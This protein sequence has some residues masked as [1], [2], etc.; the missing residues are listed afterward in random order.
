MSNE[1]SSIH[2]TC[3][4]SRLALPLQLLMA[5]DTRDFFQRSVAGYLLKPRYQIGM[6]AFV[7]AFALLF[8]NLFTPY[9][10]PESG[11][12]GTTKFM[13]LV[14]SIVLVS[15]GLVIF[16]LSRLAM[17]LWAKRHVIN[18]LQ[19]IV[20]V[21][22]EII[23]IAV[24]AA[25]CFF[26]IHVERDFMTALLKCLIYSALLI[27]PPYVA[28]V[29]YRSLQDKKSKLNKIE[30]DLDK[31][32]NQKAAGRSIISFYDERGELQLSLAKE[33]FLYIE[34]S[35]NYIAIWYLK[36]N[37][38]RKQMMRMTLQ[39]MAEQLQGTSVM[40]CHRS[41][42]VNME[43]VKVLRRDKEGFFIEMGINGVPDLPVSKTYSEEIL[44][45]LSM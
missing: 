24:I 3:F 6:I 29:I 14:W 39:R 9:H 22:M 12:M 45:W 35:D 43:Q 7:A 19:Y 23:V 25:V 2:F 36:N 34:S 8:I 18:N 20:W 44:K 42:L 38:P 21:V 27:I 10:L 5:E 41:Y 16:F 26:C 15:F 30:E 4:I 11:S 17:V 31:A 37:L 40:R 1:K 33:N 32:I 28:A 13:Y